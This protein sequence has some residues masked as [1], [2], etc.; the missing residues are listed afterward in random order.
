MGDPLKDTSGPSLNILIK[1]S[2]ILSLVFAPFFVQYG[3]ILLGRPQ[4]GPKRSV[5]ACRATVL[6][7]RGRKPPY[8]SS[9][10]VLPVSKW[11][12]IQPLFG[13]HATRVS[14]RFPQRSDCFNTL[15]D[16]ERIG[17]LYDQ[18][19]DRRI[20]CVVGHLYKSP[21]AVH[22]ALDVHCPKADLYSGTRPQRSVLQE[23]QARPLED[24]VISSF[25][26]FEESDLLQHTLCCSYYYHQT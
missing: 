17:V 20:E 21:V 3:G 1:L 22:R 26:Y 16:S 13:S 19:S 12:S 18:V 24:I 25:W 11:Y 9:H 23:Q 7:I 14:R 4:P 15:I 8:F 2:A 5:V 6:K 10:S